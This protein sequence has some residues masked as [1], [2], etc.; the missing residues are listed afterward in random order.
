L[1]RK[2]SITL[3]AHRELEFSIKYSD[4]TV[5]YSEYMLT[6]FFRES[7]KAPEGA[8]GGQQRTKRGNV[9]R[10][11]ARH[12]QYAPTLI[13]LQLRCLPIR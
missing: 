1:V 4:C 2:D 10:S 5:F 11:D 7:D 9:P 8:S 12:N 13:S 6:S 3:S